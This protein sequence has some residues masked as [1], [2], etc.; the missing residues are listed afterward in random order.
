MKLKP[1]HIVLIKHFISFV[2]KELNLHTIPPIEFVNYDL[3]SEKTFGVFNKKNSHIKV[4]AKDRHPIDVMRTIA[5][6]LT[7]YK[8]KQTKK[9]GEQKLEDDANAI[10]GRIMKKY[11]VKHGNVFKQKPM[12]EDGMSTA[13]IATAAVN[14]TGPG[15]ENIDPLLMK[16]KKKNLNVI[17]KRKVSNG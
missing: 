15:I 8:Q 3:N 17:L 12:N 9:S 10:A 4:R 13:G 11:D 14:H 16:N 2:K 7:H 5:H 1:Q 6:E